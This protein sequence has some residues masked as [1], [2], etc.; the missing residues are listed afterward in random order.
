[1]TI[2]FKK[3][4]VKIFLK[5][6]I[7]SKNTQPKKN[8]M[9]V[10]CIYTVVLHFVLNKQ[11]CKSSNKKSCE[12]FSKSWNDPYPYKAQEQEQEQE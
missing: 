12:F 10:G 2:F 7:I 3:N 4:Q 8:E 6:A 9:R 5:K 1:M 11:S